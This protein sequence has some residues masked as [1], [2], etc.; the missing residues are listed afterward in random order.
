[1]LNFNFLI[2]IFI[3]FIIS[4]ILTLGIIRLCW[5]YSLLDYPGRHKRHKK[6]TPILGGTAILAA[7]WISLLLYILF[8]EDG[9]DDLFPALPN[10]LAGS[11]L[12]YLVGLV[13][14]LKPLSAWL[15]LAIQT[16]AGLVLFFG[17]LSVEFISVPIYG[18]VPV[19]GFAVLIT[20]VWVIALS[21]AMNLID[22]LDGLATGV[23]VIASITLAIIGLLFQ[24]EGV[25][26]F[27]LALFGALL[28]FWIYN[29]YPAR[30]FLGDSGSLLIGYFF[31]VISLV[32]PIKSFATAALFMP[33]V[34]LGVPL[35]EAVSSFFR[36]L[37]AGKN[38]MKA[39]RRHIF[40][41]LA[42][43]G[44]NQRQ[45]VALFYL[46]GLFFGFISLAMILFSRV[47]VLT[48]LILFMVVIFIIYFILISRMKK[49]NAAG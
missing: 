12:I 1:M 11:L 14:D 29:R 15:K 34:V 46:T 17:G 43:A 45:I 25:V 4:L 32:F 40:H 30:I 33:L 19:G 22:G 47:M 39:D 7:V 27:S 16:L 26:V 44:L 9:L 35:I 36:R 13:D 23:S 20:V 3:S 49:D 37:A 21:N 48:F 5:K 24:V 38:V 2:L 42:Y 31:A 18:S 28:A 41:Y 10:I 8:V 6:P